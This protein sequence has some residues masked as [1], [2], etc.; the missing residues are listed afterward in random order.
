M[1]LHLINKNELFDRS[2]EEKE[3][4]VAAVLAYS[5]EDTNIVKK[6][7]VAIS[8]RPPSSHRAIFLLVSGSRRLGGS[9]GIML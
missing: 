7:T 5:F 8:S 6:G 1:L 2:V 3:Y 9:T 4:D